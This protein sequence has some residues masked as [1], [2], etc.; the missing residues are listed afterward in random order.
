MKLGF[1]FVI[2]LTMAML[3]GC[4]PSEQAKR[5]ASEV[6]GGDPARGQIAI[7]K[8]GC[9][10]CHTVDGMRQSEA[11]VGPPLTHMKRR[12]YLAGMLENNPANMTRWIQKPREVNPKTAMPDSGVTD[13]DARDIAS[14]L[15][16]F[17]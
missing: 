1:S 16:T 6:T 9:L 17:K 2:C 10:A 7:E 12:S 14:Y 4:G 5:W 15:Y 11:L 13:S 3:A 8:Y